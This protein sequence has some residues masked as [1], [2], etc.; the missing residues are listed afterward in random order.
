[1]SEGTFSVVAYVSVSMKPF[2]AIFVYCAV[3]LGAAKSL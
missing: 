2:T 3:F 1:M